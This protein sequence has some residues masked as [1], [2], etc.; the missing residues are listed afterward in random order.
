MGEIDLRGE[1]LALMKDPEIRRRMTEGLLREATEGNKSGSVIRAY[2][3]VSQIIAED[4][5]QRTA[6]AEEEDFSR[7]TDA[8][9][10]AMLQ[11]E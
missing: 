8:E 9:L 6:A 7:Y 10:Y 4:E 11:E 3:L 5:G 1:L 2:E